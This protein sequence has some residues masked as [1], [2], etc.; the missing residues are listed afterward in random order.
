MF[1][2]A[3]NMASALVIGGGLAGLTAA[4]RL[5][6]AAPGSEITV[7]E[8]GLR[9]GGQ[10][11]TERAADV[12]VERGG[13]GFVF[14]SEA[15]PSL[16][17]AVGVGDQLMGQAVFTSYGFGDRGLLALAPGEAAAYLGFQVPREDLGRGIRTLRGGMGALVDGLVR[18]LEHAHVTLRSG[19]ELTAITGPVLRARFAD[20]STLEPDCIAV[21]TTA[22]SAGG[23]LAALL[24]QEHAALQALA[25]AAAMSSVTVELELERD[26]I[27]HPLDGT[28]FVVAT[29]Q[30]EKGLRACT[31][32]T[33]KFEGRA[34]AERVLL[35]AFFRPEPADSALDDAAWVERATT[36]LGRVL[37]IERAPL[38]SWVSRWPSALPV[39]SPA[40][41][42]IVEQ[43]ERALHPRNVCLAGAAFHGSG[44]DAAVRSGEAA[45][46]FL[47]AALTTKQAAPR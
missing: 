17:S 5:A 25:S 31:F 45:A 2:R 22:A 47:A 7:V 32:T 1:K 21:A 37:P 44:I 8:R 11:W 6:E 46:R 28:G 23:V 27:A 29:A 15:V 14:R 39:H 35:R 38:R 4:L 26:A 18:T 43:L 19:L 20:G 41:A 40:H 34:P 16:A 30:Q 33:S 12:L 3:I 9:F 10:I 36:G 24:P 42:A 13:E